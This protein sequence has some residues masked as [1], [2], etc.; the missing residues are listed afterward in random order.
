MKF[1]KTFYVSLTSA[2]PK[3][4]PVRRLA[5][6]CSIN[7]LNLS[8]VS[9]PTIAHVMRTFDC[10]IPPHCHQQPF[11]NPFQKIYQDL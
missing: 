1:L 9:F 4:S 7:H 5:F 2:H 11:N 6:S 8:F 3:P 10:F